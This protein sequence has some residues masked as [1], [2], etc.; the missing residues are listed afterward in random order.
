MADATRIEGMEELLRKVNLL[1]ELQPVTGAIL[2]AGNDIILKR[3]AVYPADSRPSR[4][5]VYGSPF[6]SEK[7][8]RYFFW[9]LGEKKIEVPYRRGESPGSQVFAKRWTVMA[10]NSGMTV[11]V[12][13]NAKYGPLLMDE[14][15]Q[16]RYA[17]RVGWET[18]QDIAEEE[19]PVV[20]ELVQGEIDKLLAERK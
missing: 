9:A 6:K 7:Q 8:R 2:S 12:G 10:S 5:E 20:I 15:N 19:M 1:E 14:E 16:S 17:A 11:T 3:V 13:N 18:V 4:Y